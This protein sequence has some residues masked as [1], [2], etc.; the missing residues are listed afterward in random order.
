M[1]HTKI[2][3]LFALTFLVSW[4]LQTSCMN[5]SNKHKV[6]PIT[7]HEQASLTSAEQ[8]H[9]ITACLS[10]IN[11]KH[12]AARLSTLPKCEEGYADGWLT[13]EQKAALPLWTVKYINNALLHVGKKTQAECD[14]DVKS[15]VSEMTFPCLPYLCCYQPTDKRVKKELDDYLAELQK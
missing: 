6:I 5:S 2:S 1:K 13:V 15:V 3:L 7:E 12:E 14:R 9:H 11:D 4:N 8:I 10:V